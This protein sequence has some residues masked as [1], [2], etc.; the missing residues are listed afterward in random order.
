M[1]MEPSHC[2]KVYRIKLY[3]YAITASDF[4]VPLMLIYLRKGRRRVLR[5]EQ[6]QSQFS[7]V[8]TKA[9]WIVKCYVNGSVIS[10]QF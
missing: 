5:M 6:P 4:C 10:F 8:K 2:A 7:V 9:G 1:R 3:V